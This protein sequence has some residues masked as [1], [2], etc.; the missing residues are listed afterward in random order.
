M[1]IRELGQRKPLTFLF[2]SGEK[3]VLLWGQ[4]T[5]AHRQ[6]EEIMLTGLAET[7]VTRGDICCVLVIESRDKPAFARLDNE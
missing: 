5:L 6:Y 2:V 4:Y 3:S 7:H 1:A